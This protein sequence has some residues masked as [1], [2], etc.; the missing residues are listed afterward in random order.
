M[1]AKAKFYTVS[2]YPLFKREK[3]EAPVRLLVWFYSPLKNWF[4]LFRFNRDPITFDINSPM[5]RVY[6]TTVPLNKAPAG[7]KASTAAASNSK[8][9]G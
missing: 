4:Q 9:I 6:K 8:P 7:R 1:N 3:C 2:V 5:G